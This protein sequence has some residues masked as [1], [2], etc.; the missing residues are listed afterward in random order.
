MLILHGVLGIFVAAFNLTIFNMLLS[1][2]SMEHKT[3]AIASFHTLNALTG[4]IAPFLGTW[5]LTVLPIQGALVISSLLRC[6]GFVVFIL[7]NSS[8]LLASLGRIRE[9][10]AKRR[11][12]H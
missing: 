3:I 10:V 6:S 4:I 7:G 8:T 9:T 2:S 5:S 1:A 12:S 11:S